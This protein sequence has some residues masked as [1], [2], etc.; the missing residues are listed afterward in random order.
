M[1]FNS[2]DSPMIDNL[3]FPQTE[4][5]LNFIV[6][7]IPAEIEIPAELLE[8][9]LNQQIGERGIIP[10]VLINGSTVWKFS[11]LMQKMAVHTYLFEG[12][13]INIL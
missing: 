7:T 6:T 9:R 4:D 3:K 12:L 10:R 8:E 1:Q 13:Q 5:L 11:Q 2:S